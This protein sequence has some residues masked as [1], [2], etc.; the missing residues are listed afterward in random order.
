MS[1]EH[2]I[3]RTFALA[4]LVV[5]VGKCLHARAWMMANDPHGEHWRKLHRSK[6]ARFRH[7]DK[8]VGEGAESAESTITSDATA[9]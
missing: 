8:S 4:T 3:F 2:R 9:V 7:W 6:A 1:K 5:A